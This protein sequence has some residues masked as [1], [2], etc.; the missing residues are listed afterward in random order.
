MEL[1]LLLPPADAVRVPRLPIVRQT[2]TGRA[3]GQTM[4]VVWHDALDR[5]LSAEGLALAE[6]RGVW[7]LERHRPLATDFWPPAIGHRLIEEAAA[8]DAFTHPLPA[9]LTPVAAF[10]GRR[11]VFP[12]TIEGETVSLTML[13]G[14]LRAVAAE[15]PA[16]RLI[17]EGPD[18]AMRILLRALAENL[19]LSVPTFSLATQAVQLAD[20]TKPKPR[21]LGSPALP[22]DGDTVTIAFAHIIGHLTD[23]ILALAP[24]TDDDETEIE[25]VHQIRVAVRR[26]RSAM[27]LFPALADPTVA[28][29]LKEL[30]R[31][32]G[33]ARDW[34]V[35]M[36]E[37][38]P[39]VEAVLPTQSDLHALLR[40][41]E[42][43]RRSAHGA[44][45][46]YLAS[47]RFRALCLELAWLAAA[48]LPAIEPE[49]PPLRDFAAAV[50][51]SRWKKLT[52]AGQALDD[53]SN[54]E[55]H[56]LRL[57]AKRL[58]YAAEFFAP[59]FQEKSATR[60][61][62]RLAI[63]QDRLG[64]FNDTA[65]ADVLSRE[66]SARPGFGAGLVLGFTA[67]R[68]ANVRP[69]IVRAWARFRR[70]APFWE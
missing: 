18:N 1:T 2:R 29:G 32:L 22:H 31:V 37:T 61:I 35:F 70:R 16:A 5:E 53:L 23:V 47:P 25:A 12:L 40:A 34:D 10:E 49:P 68:G 4:R 69:K 14:T 65:S 38:A 39:P 44:L 50:L 13:H 36:T 30:G 67:A 51:H 58:R 62:R 57:K 45:A 56:G 66:L 43:R 46:E 11:T 41:G 27:S 52:N 8:P 21:R 28:A 26:A 63:L 6:Q 24:E 54:T 42:R 19:P 17:L 64:V 48:T 59:L 33:P 55:L 15:R 20:G 60:F 7:R 3:R 9:A